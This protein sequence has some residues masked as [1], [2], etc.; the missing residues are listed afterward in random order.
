MAA[1]SQTPKHNRRTDGQT[2]AGA[3][4]RAAR[5]KL[6]KRAEAAGK[7]VGQLTACTFP[8]VQAQLEP[9]WQ[10]AEHEAELEPFLLILLLFTLNS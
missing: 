6:W 10:G 8:L 5:I 1:G 7:C 9:R 4:T 3:I 2:D